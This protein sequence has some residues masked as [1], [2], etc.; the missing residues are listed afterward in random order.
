MESNHMRDWTPAPSKIL[1]YLEN[2][3][4]CLI[5]YLACILLNLGWNIVV[6]LF[7]S[8]Y[9]VLVSYHALVVCTL[10]LLIIGCMCLALRAISIDNDKRKKRLNELVKMAEEMEKRYQEYLKELE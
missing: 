10:L 7:G 8:Q 9:P 6:L 4:I 3:T 1:T 2:P 5:A